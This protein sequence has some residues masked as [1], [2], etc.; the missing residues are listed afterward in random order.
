MRSSNVQSMMLVRTGEK[1]IQG[2]FHFPPQVL[3][4]FLL[5]AEPMQGYSCQQMNQH[6]TFLSVRTARPHLLPCK[7]N[8]S[9]YQ[10]IVLNNCS[11]H[12]TMPIPEPKSNR[13]LGLNLGSRILI[14]FNTR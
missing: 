9:Q 10:K 14:S 13:F 12:V 1:I 2:Q 8:A 3:F 7:V 6:K 11:Y 4:C 5:S